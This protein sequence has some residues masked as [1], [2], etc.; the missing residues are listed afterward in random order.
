M[1]AN[2]I[3]KILN[4]FSKSK[5][6]KVLITGSWGIGKTKYVKDFIKNRKD[7]TTCYIS[8]FGKKDINSI[9][10]ELYFHIIK[11]ANNAFV[12]K[13][14]TN[15]KDKL[16]S[17]DFSYLGL[18]LSIP[19]IEDLYEKI[20]KELDRDQ[21]YLFIFDDLERKHNDLCIKEVFG[22][23]D[24]LS[25]SPNIKTVLITAIE[26]L[27]GDSKKDF[28]NYEE[29]AIDRTYKI[30]EYS[31]DAPV[32]ILGEDIWNVIGT[33]AEDYKFKNLRT[34]EKINLF[35]EE[36][37]DVLGEE[38]FTNKF[39][40]AD[41]YRM[42]FASVLF[43]I[44]HKNEM[45]LLEESDST[46]KSFMKAYYMDKGDSGVV[47][48]LNERILKNS[49]DNIM[50]KNVFNY[51]R[52]WY[53]TGE[54]D[55]KK[56]LNTIE[57]INSY[58]EEPLNFFSSEQEILDYI[59]QSEEYFRN[60][61]GNES[62]EKVISKVSNV[63]QWCDVLSIDFVF[64]NKDFS[65]NI[66]DN[67]YNNI[68]IE[69]DYFYNQQHAPFHFYSQ[70]EKVNELIE[71]IES[72]F[73]FEYYSKLFSRINDCFSHHSYNY[74]YLRALNGSMA[75]ITETK[76]RNFILDKLKDNDYFFP[77]PSDKITGDQWY[78]CREINELVEKIESHWEI[79]D[80]HYNFVTHI[81]NSSN[82]E[83]D[84]MLKYRLSDLFNL[85]D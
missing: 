82:L 17:L 39:T 49:L 42:A 53:E 16:K 75:N 65:N 60:L 48:Y 19:L 21:T 63:L 8:L 18:S 58:E 73:K 70:T 29:K 62:L 22:L 20:N 84:K 40:K 44:E 15:I 52:K 33:I 1:K 85:V 72:D 68:N 55:E 36:L 64:S 80:Y 12:K 81:V 54:Y 67:I 61:N 45:I 74:N 57:L 78:W 34:F 43:K 79:N 38:V 50:S 30:D 76:I 28:V 6:Q 14:I 66:K 2:K 37:I 59:K 10:H 51:I 71:I 25:K 41:L 77:I 69:E 9:I 35:I 47:D 13:G 24:S 46:N 4:D 27:E 5:Y 83:K 7:I 31:V 11:D 26:Q 23:I 32:N 56:I 3:V